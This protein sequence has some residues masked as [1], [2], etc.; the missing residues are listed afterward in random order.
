MKSVL[1]VLKLK[2]KGGENM[3]KK[4]FNYV[5]L[6]FLLLYRHIRLLVNR[7]SLSG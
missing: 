7:F 1:K 4:G 6:D 3:K 5:V 2:Q